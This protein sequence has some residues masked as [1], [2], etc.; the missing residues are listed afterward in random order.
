MELRVLFGFLPEECDREIHH[1]LDAVL[2]R[3]RVDDDAGA[4]NPLFFQQFAPRMIYTSY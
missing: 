2:R 3:G 1:R 4:F